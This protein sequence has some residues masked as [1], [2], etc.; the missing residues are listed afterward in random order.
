MLSYEPIFFGVKY[1]LMVTSN[2]KSITCT[3]AFSYLPYNLTSTRV[4]TKD[5]LLYTDIFSCKMSF[6]ISMHFCVLIHSHVKCALVN[7]FAL[8]E[9]SC[10]F[11]L[12]AWIY[13]HIESSFM[14]GYIFMYNGNIYFRSHTFICDN[15]F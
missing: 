10:K 15:C 3:D 11:R 14:R 5:A 9:F 7:F 1:S 8:I 4:S 2:W 12:H 13:L 6:H